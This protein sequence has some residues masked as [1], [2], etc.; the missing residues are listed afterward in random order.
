MLLL[1]VGKSLKQRRSSM[2]HEGISEAKAVSIRRCI[3]GESL[4]S[5]D[6]Q[7]CEGEGVGSWTRYER[8]MSLS[9]QR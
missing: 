1:R 4:H 3:S 8:I 6:T 2:I 5:E 9:G 7:S